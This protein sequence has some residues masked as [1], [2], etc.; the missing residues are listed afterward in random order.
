MRA[1]N[2]Q[3]ASHAPSHISRRRSNRSPLRT[4]SMLRRRRSCT[5]AV[6]RTHSDALPYAPARRSRRRRPC[7]RR[8]APD[9]AHRAIHSHLDPL[10][11][12]PRRH[13]LGHRR[14]RRG[15]RGP[16]RLRPPVLPG[17]L[18]QRRVPH[19]RRR[20]PRLP[21]QPGHR[22]P[23]HRRNGSLAHRDRGRR[24]GL[25][26][27]HRRDSRARGRVAVDLARGTDPRPAHGPRHP[28]RVGRHPR[29]VERG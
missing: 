12:L 21:A 8:G 22:G 13:R 27:R 9:P 23:T 2:I 18:V 5:Y 4:G 26:G 6:L 10:P 1:H 29:P 20:G 19:L 25:G 24:R 15:R 3:G 11:A 7:A 14:R 16:V 28:L 17:R